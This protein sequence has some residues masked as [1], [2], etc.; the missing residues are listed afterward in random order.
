MSTGE[1]QRAA[2]DCEGRLTRRRVLQ[3]G[4]TLATGAA[5][6][7]RLGRLLDRLQATEAPPGAG[8]G[9]V[10]HVVIV[11]QE[12]RSFDCYFG[13]LSGV[14]GFDDRRPSRSYPGGPSTDPATV[15]QQQGFRLGDQ[16][17]LE[18]FPLR[19]H[20]PFENGQTTNDI[21][22]DWVPQHLSWANGAMSAFVTQ[23]LAADGTALDPEGQEVPNGILTMGHFDRRSL[24][25][26]YALADAFTICDHYFCSLMGPTDPNRLMWLSASIGADGEQG[27]PV[28]QTY[29]V[30]RAAHLGTLG[31]QTMPERL[32]QAGVSWKVYQDP[33]SNA[34]F[35]V[36]D[37][38]NSFVDPAS[39]GQAELAARGLLPQY[40]AD[41]VADVASGRLPAVSWLI[42]PVA[43]CE[44]PA[45]P[46]EYGEWFVAQVLQTLVSNPEIWERTVLF[47]VY[48][49]N[50]G[51]F[52]HVAPPTPGPLVTSLGAVPTGETYA[53][54]YLTGFD[55]PSAAG[56]IRG[57]LGLGFRVP[58][59]VVSPFSRGGWVCSEVF[60]HTSTLRFLERRF[61]VGVPNLSP[62]R[63]SVT[64]DLTAALPLLT[65]PDPSVPPL[66]PTSLLDPQV[67]TQAVINAVTGTADV[68]LG[69]PPPSRNTMPHQE[70]RPPRRPTPT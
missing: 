29:V 68:G 26:Y 56:G 19:S 33:T 5:L 3:A 31:W 6:H 66:P 61:G 52:D 55:L 41:F 1:E 24:P 62:W 2:A 22:H 9:D 4:G 46:P 27:G 54:E 69:Y 8:L 39:P 43:C 15:F 25:F 18:P 17:F 59:L 40:P 63:R 37:Y 21:T 49:E 65:R 42:P 67:A 36:L 50:G 14:R 64:G 11:M 28:V 32:S 23:H 60:D 30:H 57:P 16:P 47:V 38:F 10:E 70:Q 51:F 12:N 53:G 20:P 7:G 48:D 13:T 58:C 44:H 35:N 34:L 45:A